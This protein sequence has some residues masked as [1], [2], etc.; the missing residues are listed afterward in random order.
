MSA[1]TLENLIAET[2]DAVSGSTD[3]RIVADAVGE[4]LRRLVGGAFFPSEADLAPAKESFAR[5]EL[6]RDS[7]V[8][9]STAVWLPQQSSPIHDHQGFGVIAALS[10]RIIATTYR[11]ADD[12]A[13]PGFASL[14]EV[15]RVLVSEASF[16]MLRPPEESIH[17][18]ENTFRETAVT[19]HVFAAEADERNVYDTKAKSLLATAAPELLGV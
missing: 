12:G 7:R 9:I 11:R 15:S 8:I 14:G 3:A 13:T 2:R 16:A 10:G 17:S 18:L 19:V 5:H 6:Y 4:A 1:Y